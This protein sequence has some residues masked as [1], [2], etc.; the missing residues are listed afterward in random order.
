MNKYQEIKQ[1]LLFIC[2]VQECPSANEGEPT[3]TGA[4]T[5]LHHTQHVAN[6]KSHALREKIDYAIKK[7]CYNSSLLNSIHLVLHSSEYQSKSTIFIHYSSTALE[8]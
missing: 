8:Y 1:S 2:V 7:Q 4:T 5:A 3:A 6:S